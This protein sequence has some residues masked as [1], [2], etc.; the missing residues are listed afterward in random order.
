V[1]LAEPEAQQAL[2]AWG[3][4]RLRDLPWRRTRDPWGVLVSEVMLQQTQALRVVPRWHSFLDRFPT[5]RACASAPLGDVLREWQGLG[6]PRRAA[7]LHRAAGAMVER[8]S[9]R[10]PSTLSDL[11]ALPGIGPYTARAVLAFA[12]EADAAVVDTN[13]ARVLARSEGARLS[14]KAAQAAADAALPDGEAWAWNQ[15]MIDLGAAVCRP[16]APSCDTCPIE[17]WCTWAAAGRPA[18]DPAVGSAHVSRSQ[19]PF[20]GSDRQ[21]RGRLL[22]RLASGSLTDSEVP[23]ACGLGHDHV[24]ATAVLTSLV[25]DGLVA[26]LDDGSLTLP[27]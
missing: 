21:A 14:A 7:N 22:A 5:P 27:N 23:D 1:S 18:P 9:G 17:P 10:V 24:R 2:L 19:A 16:V 15:S 8:C 13:V 25:A 12:F 26:R 4:P 11:L 20:D 6:Y 3:V